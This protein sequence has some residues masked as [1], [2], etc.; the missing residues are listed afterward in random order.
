MIKSA[1]PSFFGQEVDVCV[2]GSGAGGAPI[3]FE[4]ARAGASVRSPARNLAE[5]ARV[6][7]AISS[8]SAVTGRFVST[9]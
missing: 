9:R 6:F 8:S 2:V 5:R 1:M 3:A 4:L 7:L